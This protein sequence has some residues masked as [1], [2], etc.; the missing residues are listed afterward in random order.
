[1]VFVPEEVLLSEEEGEAVTPECGDLNTEFGC[2]DTES[3]TRL[4]DIPEQVGALHGRII[5]KHCLWCHGQLPIFL[6]TVD[7]L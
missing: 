3:A 6:H 1:M 2:Q 4:S 7:I 5:S